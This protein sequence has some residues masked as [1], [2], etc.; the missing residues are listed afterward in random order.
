[1]RALVAAAL[2][3]WATGADAVVRCRDARGRFMKCPVTQPAPTSAAGAKFAVGSLVSHGDDKAR[4][5]VAWSVLSLAADP[6][7]RVIVYG[8]T[9]V[10]DPAG[11][12]PAGAPYWTGYTFRLNEQDLRP[13]S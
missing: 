12:F 3:L 7:Q 4:F 13:A 6:A 5:R 10:D 11:N 8:V 1:M 9:F 2:L